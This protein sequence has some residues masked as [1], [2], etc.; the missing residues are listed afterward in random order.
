MAPKV[1]VRLFELSISQGKSAVGDD[2]QIPLSKVTVTSSEST[3]VL[4]ALQSGKLSGDGV[5]TKRC[6]DL[7]EARLPGVKALLTHSC[8][9][10]LEMAALLCRLEPGDEV[11][12]PTYTFSSTANCVAWRRAGFCGH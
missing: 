7:L 4:E 3:Y 5:F 11:I 6:H 10:A 2:R 12:M 9:G 8:T 1:Y